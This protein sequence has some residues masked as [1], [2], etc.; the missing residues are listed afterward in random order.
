MIISLDYTPFR[1]MIRPLSIYSEKSRSSGT[2]PKIKW[3]VDENIRLYAYHAPNALSRLSVVRLNKKSFCPLN[4][5]YH[6][7]LTETLPTRGLGSISGGDKIA[8][9]TNPGQDDLTVRVKGCIFNFDKERQTQDIKF[10]KYL[11]PMEQ[12]QVRG[13]IPLNKL[14]NF[15]VLAPGG[16]LQLKIRNGT[17]KLVAED[18][19]NRAY[20]DIT[21]YIVQY[22]DEDDIAYLY[23]LY[24]MLNIMR[25]FPWN[26]EIELLIN[27]DLMRLRYELGDG[28]GHVSYFQ[29]G[30]LESSV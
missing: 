21:E 8:I 19:D 2:A 14:H 29:R 11:L 3:E 23:D 18:M 15:L 5:S 20:F 1:R 7:F 13:K 28:L 16:P 26:G 22:P 24:I 10:K 25:K 6:N 9:E 12:A 17:V 27:G 30:K 4:E